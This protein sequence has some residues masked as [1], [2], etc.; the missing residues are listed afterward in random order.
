MSLTLKPVPLEYAAATWPLVEQMLEEAANFSNGDYNIEQVKL[1]VNTGA[2]TLLVAVDDENMIHGAAAVSFINYPNSRVAF[3]TCSGGKG[4]FNRGVV[5]Q[6]C[7][8][9]K[10]MGATKVQATSRESVARLLQR[11]G[12]DRCAVVLDIKI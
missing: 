4:I 10:S 3:V 7:A 12:F 9:A 8:I 6:L 5:E 11:A 2:W 1:Y